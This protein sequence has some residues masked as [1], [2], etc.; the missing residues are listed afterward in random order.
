[1]M[2]RHAGAG[3]LR[4]D[5]LPRVLSALVMAGL[6]AAT[7][8]AGGMIFDLFWAA[9]AAVVFCEWTALV[10]AP[11][12]V[13]IGGIGVFALVSAAL[14]AGGARSGTAVAILA[15]A[16]PAIAL[17]AG[18]GRRGIAAA[19]LAYAGA[20]AVAV[21][22][23]RRSDGDGLAAVAWLFAVV[24]GTDTMA[25][26][27]GRMIGGPKLA[28]RLSPSKTWSGFT[29]GVV[30]GALLGLV[31][32]P[33]SGCPACVL[34]AGLW[35]GALAQAGD[36]FESSLKR[37]FGKKDAGSLVPGHG[38]LMDRL[39]GF[40]ATTVFAAAV[41]LWRFG[42]SNAGSGLLQW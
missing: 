12:P 3:R 18:R 10:G 38:G 29:V 17:L 39:D 36:L 14:L 7:A 1:M 34:L 23:L 4:G 28:P 40:I 31:V 42:P 35:G 5:L 9:A 41:G 2:E 24:W 13:P 21:P 15:C 26:F 22:L 25:Y 16:A 27:G 30:S 32:A 37:R 11:R 20:I 8:W 6:A 33:R 19:G